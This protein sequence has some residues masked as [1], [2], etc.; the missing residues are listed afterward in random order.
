MH[1]YIHTW[2]GVG[3]ETH[4][5]A[6]A[7]AGAQLHSPAWH[8]M[9]AGRVHTAWPQ[10]AARV[11]LCVPQEAGSGQ[12]VAAL[13][14]LPFFNADSCPT[15]QPLTATQSLMQRMRA[16]QE[17]MESEAKEEEFYLNALLV[18]AHAWAKGM[19]VWE[20][21]ESRGGGVAGWGAA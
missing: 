11:R 4:A 14:W 8:S 6:T 12:G 10:G 15:H 13:R 17:A 2:P 20:V 1:M 7:T 9:A 21:M 18:C 16:A 3:G 19:M 5:S